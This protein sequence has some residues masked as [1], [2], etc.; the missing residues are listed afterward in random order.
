[1]AH[2]SV[3]HDFVR[4]NL[5]IIQKDLVVLMGELCVQPEDLGRYVKDGYLLVTPTMTV[6]LDTLVEDIEKQKVTSK[7]WATPGATPHGVTL[8]LARTI[9][10]RAERRVCALRDSGELKNAEILVYLNR[11]S[12]LLW[13]FARWLE[14]KAETK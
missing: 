9:C 6:T 5:L 13:L 11:L 12:D 4:N 14:A 10:R 3:Q 7:G 8:D 2:T 1:M